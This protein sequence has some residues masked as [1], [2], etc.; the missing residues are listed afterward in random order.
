M[1]TEEN[2]IQFMG[3]GAIVSGFIGAAIGAYVLDKSSE[4]KSGRSAHR[5]F[6]TN[7]ARKQA[8]LATSSGS[9]RNGWK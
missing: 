9:I 5:Q 8:A 1:L 7:Y 3:L 4:V 6:C 2:V